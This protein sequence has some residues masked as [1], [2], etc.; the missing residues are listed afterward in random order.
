MS[1]EYMWRVCVRQHF[2]P[3]RIFGY[4]NHGRLPQVVTLFFYIFIISLSEEGKIRLH[5]EKRCHFF[6]EP[7]TRKSYYSIFLL[8][9]FLSFR[10]LWLS[11]NIYRNYGKKEIMGEFF[12]NKLYFPSIE[13]WDYQ[14]REWNMGTISPER[15]T[16][17]SAVTRH[18]FNIPI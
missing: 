13:N 16:V 15:K 4:K 6:W 1:R 12:L 9:H 8:Q 3:S 2:E 7:T 14:E 11:H 17:I 18:S 5:E 10:A